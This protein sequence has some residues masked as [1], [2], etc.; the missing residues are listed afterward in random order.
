VYLRYNNIK[1]P[2]G[3]LSREFVLSLRDAF[4]VRSFVE[5]GTY[6]GDTLA[7]LCGDFDILRSIELSRD[8]YTRA[9]TRFANQPQIHLINA[10]S[11]TGLETALDSLSEAR[12][13]FWL[14]AH[15]SGGDTAKGQSNTPIKSELLAILAR[16]Q[17]SDIILIDDLRYFWQARPGF[18]QH[19]ALP[20]Y[21]AVRDLV[22][23][24]NTQGRQYD[25]FFLCDALLAVPSNLRET[26]E[27]SPILRALTRSREG[28]TV[29]TGLSEVERL[30]A[31]VPE[32]E[33][34]ALVE[35]PDYLASQSEYG[36]GGHYY[37]WRALIRLERKEMALAQMDADIAARCGV[38]PDGSLLS[39]TPSI[40]ER[41]A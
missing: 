29:E 13:I 31:T 15:Y 30:I 21:P 28:L 20:G 12:T 39:A 1:D 19:D 34:S 38:V 11:T 22:G 36:L 8:Y 16:Q 10:D 25:C 37:Y 27:V 18:L 23:L 4:G 33:L 40:G 35:I 26:Y 6:L 7:K 32:P 24:L 5:T 14:D 17:R 9:V 41:P 3:A 2:S